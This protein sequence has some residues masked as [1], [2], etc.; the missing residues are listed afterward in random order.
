[1]YN[2]V[3]RQVEVDIL[4]ACKYQNMAV[5]P[6]SPLGGGLLRGKYRD[7]TAGRLEYDRTYAARC[8]QAWMHDRATGLSALARRN[9][10]LAIMLAVAWV[11]AVARSHRH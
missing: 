11:L 8:R 1:M 3:Q 6:F 9:A 10:I 5:C 7:G 4:P 2:L